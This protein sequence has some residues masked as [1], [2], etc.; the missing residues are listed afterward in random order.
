MIISEKQINALLVFVQMYTQSG[1]PR[2]SRQRACDLLNEVAS[3][4]SNELKVIE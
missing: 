3:Q 1:E 4:Q 2:D